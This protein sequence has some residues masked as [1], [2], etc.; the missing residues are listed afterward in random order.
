[1]VLFSGIDEVEI[2]GEGANHVNSGIQVAALHDACYLLA[3]RSNFLLDLSGL[4]PG[5]RDKGFTAGTEK[6]ALAAYLLDCFKNGS[7]FVL[8]YGLSECVS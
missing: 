5:G 7:A 6:L 2:D 8:L 1:M 3:E 4:C